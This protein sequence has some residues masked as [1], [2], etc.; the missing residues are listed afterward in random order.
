MEICAE[1]GGRKKGEFI[2]PEVLAKR[3]IHLS[4]S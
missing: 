1:Y 3:K 4:R 2:L